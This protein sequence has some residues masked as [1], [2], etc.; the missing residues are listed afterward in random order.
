MKEAPDNN[1]LYNFSI[2]ELNQYF[3]TPRFEHQN[4]EFKSGDVHIREVAREIAGFLNSQGG[5]LIVGAPKETQQGKRKVCQGIL[6]QSTFA[7]AQWIM[8]QVN[9]L[10][11]PAPTNHEIAIRGVPEVHP[12]VFLIQVRSSTRPPH[13]VEGEGRYYIRHKAATKPATHAE[14]E[15]LFWK[16]RQ[17]QLQQFFKLGTRKG[18]PA[19]REIFTLEIVNNSRV[20]AKEIEIELHTNNIEEIVL[21]KEMKA[22]FRQVDE[23]TIYGKVEQSLQKDASWLQHFTITNKFQPYLLYCKVWGGQA[24]LSNHLIVWDPAN[25]LVLHDENGKHFKSFN[26][27]DLQKLITYFIP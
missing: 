6:T 15:S 3:Q 24:L 14:V 7:T 9:V 20:A 22:S 23:H 8:E 2:H 17:P 27:N 16:D 25:K 1:A 10:L 13:M 18:M 19:N 12:Q 5:L 4:L 26:P 21:H 11:A